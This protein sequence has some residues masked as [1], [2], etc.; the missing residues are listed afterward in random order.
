MTNLEAL[1][2]KYGLYKAIERK[3]IDI[4]EESEFVLFTAGWFDAKVKQTACVKKNNYY[5]HNP[6]NSYQDKFLYNIF[7]ASVTLRSVV[8]AMH[9]DSQRIIVNNSEV[10]FI[11]PLSTMCD[12]ITDPNAYHSKTYNFSNIQECC[13]VAI[14]ENRYNNLGHFKAVREASEEASIELQKSYMKNQLDIYR[15]AE[16]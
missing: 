5:L 10:R 15:R 13:S 3:E 7:D 12:F 14:N 1:F 8:Y 11:I 9:V 2:L 4:V 16:Q 6:F